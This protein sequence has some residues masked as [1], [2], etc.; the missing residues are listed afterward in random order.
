MFV[1]SESKKADSYYET[2]ENIKYNLS[3]LRKERGVTQ[4]MLSIGSGVSLRTIKRVEGGMSEAENYQLS[5]LINICLYFGVTLAYITADRP[6]VNTD[7]ADSIKELLE[8]KNVS[9]KELPHDFQNDFSNYVGTENYVDISKLESWNRI[10]LFKN[11]ADIKKLPPAK[12]LAITHLKPN[13]MYSLPVKYHIA[14]YHH[15]RTV[16][17]KKY[18]LRIVDNG[19]NINIKI[20]EYKR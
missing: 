15:I 13:A 8:K 10:R 7:V 17:D 19:E 3:K 1:V 18:T 2:Y 14:A 5:T 6:I 4:E 16:K 11:H 9:T 20:Y 12:Q